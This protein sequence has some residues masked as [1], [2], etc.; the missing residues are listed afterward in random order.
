[1]LA[2]YGLSKRYWVDAF[3]TSVYIINRLPTPILANSSPF[4][5]LYN[6]IPEYSLLRVFG[7]KCFPLLHPYTVHK[8]EY[9]S[10]SCIFLGYSHKGY[11]C[12]DPFSDK[13]YLSRHVFY[14]ASFPTKENATLQLSTKGNAVSDA[15]FLQ[16]VSFP[17]VLSSL[18]NTLIVTHTNQSISPAI[19]R[20]F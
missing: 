8:L 12:L 9:R 10:K 6:K 18:D 16:Y 15:S 4:E 3:L 1:L 11:R 5:K 20:F 14:E 17:H 19:L 7:C 2:H 13:V